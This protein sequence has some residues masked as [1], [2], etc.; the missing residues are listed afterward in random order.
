MQAFIRG[1]EKNQTSRSKGYRSVIRCPNPSSRSLEGWRAKRS[2]HDILRVSKRLET[3]EARGQIGSLWHNEDGM[4]RRA[5]GEGENHLLRRFCKMG[6]VVELA[7][8]SGDW[9]LDAESGALLS[10]LPPDLCS[11]CK[12]RSKA[13]FDS[14][15]NSVTTTTE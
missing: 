13:P 15:H 8:P 6:E 9:W 5:D 3:F 7:R 11:F 4:C 14:K 12:S 10:C 2:C 1:R